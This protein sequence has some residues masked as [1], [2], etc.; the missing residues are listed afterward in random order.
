MGI[1]KGWV[2]KTETLQCL[3]GGPV[4]RLSHV[5]SIAACVSSLKTHHPAAADE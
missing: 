5:D 2:E 3:E 4:V 1:G